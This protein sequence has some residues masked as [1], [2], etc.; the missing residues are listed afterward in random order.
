M[1]D[2]DAI[3]FAARPRGACAGL[4]WPID[5]GARIRVKR[6]KP[7]AERGE[8]Q[9]MDARGVTERTADEGRARASKARRTPESNTRQRRILSGFQG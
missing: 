3:G 5:K 1:H 7:T 8:Q 9:P 2:V 4:C 6:A